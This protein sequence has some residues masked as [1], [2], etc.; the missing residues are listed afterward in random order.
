[1]DTC[2]AG[3]IGIGRHIGTAHALDEKTQV[4]KVH[5][6]I[7]VYSSQAARFVLLGDSRAAV[8]DLK[9][10]E[11]LL[12]HVRVAVHIA[13]I[14]DRH[15]DGP[16]RRAHVEPELVRA[17]RTVAAGETYLSPAIAGNVVEAYL[18][19]ASAA[20]PSASTPLTPRQREV[21]QLLAEGWSTK[22]MAVRLHVSVK[23]IETHRKQI[24]DELDI[25]SV[26]ELTK[27]AVREG[28]TSLEK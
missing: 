1:M 11:V 15:V 19:Q 13:G 20:G 14:H 23:T 10:P 3:A 5:V 2:S 24:M 4:S 6:L 25:H 12:V 27:F 9:Q 18:A 21:L 16:E 7:R 26:A 28:L 22:Q 17:I 8:T